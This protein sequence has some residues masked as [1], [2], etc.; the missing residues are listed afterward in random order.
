MRQRIRDL[1]LRLCEDDLDDESEDQLQQF[2]NSH[3]EAREVYIDVVALNWQLES[4]V[5]RKDELSFFQ[6]P[7]SSTALTPS[8]MP[9]LSGSSAQML[10]TFHWNN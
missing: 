5:A 2:L 7:R 9:W 6:S 8:A 10:E 1:A 4:L 3:P